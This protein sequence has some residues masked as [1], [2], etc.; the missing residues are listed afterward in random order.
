MKANM[1]NFLEETSSRLPDKTAF[2]DDREKMTYGALTDKARR[3]GSALAKAAS[4]RRPVALLMDARSIRNIPAMFGVLYAGCAYAPLDI[5]M[6]KDRLKLLLDLLQ[7]AAVLSDE[8][9]E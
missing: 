1:L 4:P 6:P 5:M 3:I 7:P 8:K 2:Y 9:G